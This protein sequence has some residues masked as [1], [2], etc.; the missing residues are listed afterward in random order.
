MTQNL[1]QKNN[2]GHVQP[3]HQTDYIDDKS[4]IN[5]TDSLRGSARGFVNSNQS[6]PQNQANRRYSQN[7]N[8][9]QTSGSSSI[10]NP[11]QSSHQ[12]MS[13]NTSNNNV[14][15]SHINVLNHF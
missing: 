8:G 11:R 1:F 15:T 10:A 6:A 5:F 3:R 12:K 4:S 14:R 2:G 7:P 13:S 9:P